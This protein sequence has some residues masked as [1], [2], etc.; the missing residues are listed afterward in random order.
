VTIQRQDL[1]R[2][3]FVL[4][5]KKELVPQFLEA[6]QNVWPEYLEALTAAGFEHY[7]SFIS[8]DGLFV[9][10]LESRDPE[11]SLAKLGATEID[12]RWQ[13]EMIPF[14][15][16][17][18]TAGEDSGKSLLQEAFDLDEALATP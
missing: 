13:L 4:H 11:A 8:P 2:G 1:K 17:E 12:R 10:Y 9:G 7:S 16:P 14:W 5:V 18:K 6:H 3:C 15:D